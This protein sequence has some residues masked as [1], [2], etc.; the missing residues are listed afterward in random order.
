MKATSQCL[1]AKSDSK[2][3]GSRYDVKNIA[4]LHS[5]LVIFSVPLTAFPLPLAY[6]FL[7][8]HHLK[9]IVECENPFEERRCALRSAKRFFPNLGL[10]L[11]LGDR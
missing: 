7:M 3:E 11:G 6:V 10:E 9:V 2:Q 4:E 8:F 1:Q 5:L